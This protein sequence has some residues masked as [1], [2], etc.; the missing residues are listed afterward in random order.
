MSGLLIAGNI[1]VDRHINGAQQNYFIGPLNAPKVAISPGEAE[2]V[3]RKSYQ[4]DTYGQVLDSVSLPGTPSIDITIDEAS[5]EILAFALLGSTESVTQAAGSVVDEALTIVAL[6]RWH[7]LPA[8]DISAVTVTNS[9]GTTT[10]VAGVDYDLD[11]KTGA[12]RALSGG[13]IAAAAPLKLDYTKAATSG[14]RVLGS[15]VSSITASIRLDGINMATQK[16]VNFIAH[17]AVLSPSG[18]IDLSGD[19]FVS[20]GLKGDLVTPEG[21]SAP[22]YIDMGS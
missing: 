15:Q 3:K 10:Y 21:Y 17:K 6:D 18:E 11:L 14:T 4:R 19:A 12:L 16:P 7:K 8:H 5:P 9:A 2:V 1:M 13:A 20:F 22:Y